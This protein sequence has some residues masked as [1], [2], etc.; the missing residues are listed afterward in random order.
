[1]TFRT[2][3][4][5]G[6]LRRKRQLS[7]NEEPDDT[8]QES[9]YGVTE[10]ARSI[11]G[12]NSVQG[13]E[14][15]R[16]GNSLDVLDDMKNLFM[17]DFDTDPK[18]KGEREVQEES[19]NEMETSLKDTEKDVCEPSPGTRIGVEIPTVCTDLRW[20]VHFVMLSNFLFVDTSIYESKWFEDKQ[21]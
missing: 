9:D 7:S 3:G 12:D 13:S 16:Q 8:G 1:M 6:K 5:D 20:E 21:R 10:K 17:E 2:Y 15:G 11:L 14:V 4:A 18:E 19:I